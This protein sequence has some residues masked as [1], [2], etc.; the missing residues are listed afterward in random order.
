MTGLRPTTAARRALLA[1][2]CAAAALLGPVTPGAVAEPSVG[3]RQVRAALRGM[4]TI[5][6]TGEALLGILARSRDE[7]GDRRTLAPAVRLRTAAGLAAVRLRAT[8]PTS[9]PGHRMRR[10]GISVALL[11]REAARMLV[12]AERAML[13][14]RPE[15]GVRF[16][17]KAAV[18]HVAIDGRTDTARGIVLPD[19]E[20]TAGSITVL[21]GVSLPPDA[22][23]LTP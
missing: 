19:P 18:L 15:R 3:D 9:A 22:F 6:H 2:G 13:A 7:G 23:I 4:E 17:A 14:G 8:S 20:A 5:D 11:H 16:L 10:L 12:A 21:G 1:G